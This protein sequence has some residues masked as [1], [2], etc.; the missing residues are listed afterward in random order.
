MLSGL[1]PWQTLIVF[2][3]AVVAGAGNA[4]AGGG[5][6]LSFPILVWVGLPAVEANATNAVGLL[7]GSLAAAWSYR[8]RIGAAEPRWWWML[9]PAVLGGVAGA[10][11]LLGLPATWFASIAPL[12]VIGAAVVVALDP[13][14]KRYI[15]I[16]G[17]NGM[18]LAVGVMLLVSVYGGYFGAGLGIMTLIA[19]SMIGMH[20]LHQANGFKNML[21]VAVKGVAVAI[22]IV[23]GR[24]IW[25]AAVVMLLGSVAG[26]WSAGYLVQK[27]EHGTL[28]WLVVG[29][30]LAM[31]AVM[32]A[33]QYLL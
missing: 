6:N 24:V 16:D 4:V 33:R 5:T 31:G 21:V 7:F 29:M 23:Q 20:D 15:R 2:L 18:A 26:G 28:R 25:G 1:D 13:A 22:F 27:V 3:A 11:L 14:L 8:A 19:L 12:L 32:V 9:V 17:G 10:W 30:G